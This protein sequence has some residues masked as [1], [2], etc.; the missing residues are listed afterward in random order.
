MLGRVAPMI[1]YEPL[2]TPVLDLA[3]DLARGIRVLEKLR[4]RSPWVVRCHMQVL[5]MIYTASQFFYG[6]RFEISPATSLEREDY[7]LAPKLRP[8]SPAPNY[9]G[10]VRA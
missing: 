7:V 10:H 1:A 5:D 6:H 4:H 2:S 3:A 8:Q 9:L